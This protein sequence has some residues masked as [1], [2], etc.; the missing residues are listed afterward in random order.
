M[1]TNNDE[2]PSLR[3]RLLIFGGAAAAGVIALLVLA[4]V[5][6]GLVSSSS[7]SARIEDGLA[8]TVV[9][10][11][12][13][14]ASAIYD[15]LDA[16]GV[17]TYRE[18]ERVVNEAGAQERLQAGTY[19]METGMAGSEVLRLLLEGGTSSNARTI[20]IVE[21]WTVTRI[22]SELAERTEHTQ[23]QFTEALVVGSVTSPYLPEPTPGV[24]ELQR[25]EGLLYPAKYQIPQGTPVATTLQNM[26]DEMVRRFEAVDW[27]TIEDLGITRYEALVIGS[28]IEREAGTDEDR[29]VI[30]SVVHNR[31]AIRMRLQ[32]DATVIYA[33]GSNPGRVLAEHLDT[34]SPYNTY[35]TDGLPPTPIGTVSQASLIAA[36]LPA[37]TDYLFYVLSSPDGSHA[38]AVTYDQHQE[39][40]RDARA[41]GIL[42]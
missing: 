5:F 11:P 18:M 13:S 30:S 2:G 21:G 27:S 1:H 34:P 38:F 32:I 17:V 7:P 10:A 22:V 42:P 3:S 28:L 9:V 23:E 12:G 8:V 33:L 16:A 37:T 20:T 26:A 4:N 24:T 31:L 39:N 15:S 29:A 36:V 19:D 25:W 35:L 41:A 14:P 6:A 40:V